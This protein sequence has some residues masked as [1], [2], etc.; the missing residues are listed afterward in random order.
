MESDANALIPV[1]NDLEKNGRLPERM[2]ADSLY[3][4]DQNVVSAAGRGVAIISPVAGPEPKQTPENPTEKQKRLQQRREIQETPEWREEYNSRAQLEGTIGS[5]KR[6]TGMVQLRYRG[7]KS[8]YSS[9]YLKLAGWNISRAV[10]CARIQEKLREIV[11]KALGRLKNDL[12]CLYFRKEI[13][14]D[15]LRRAI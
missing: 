1:L 6:R 14:L 7:E 5:I 4:G 2:T 10:H 8:M 3:G 9:I 12:I 11:P 13:E 15:R